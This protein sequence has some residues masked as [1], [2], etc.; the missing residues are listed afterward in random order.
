MILCWT[1]IGKNFIYDSL[2]C[3]VFVPFECR[4]KRKYAGLD[5]Y[6]ATSKAME[7]IEL[8]NGLECKIACNSSKVYTSSPWRYCYLCVFPLVASRVCDQLNLLPWMQCAQSCLSFRVALDVCVHCE[9]LV[10]WT[11]HLR[12]I[13]CMHNKWSTY[14]F[15]A[16]IW[17]IR[18]SGS[19]TGHR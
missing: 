17:I 6:L 8:F 16:P 12:S 7:D 11:Q 9:H 5:E 13:N 2:I 19:P 14:S 1:S 18:C 10:R 4:S 15:H 3:F